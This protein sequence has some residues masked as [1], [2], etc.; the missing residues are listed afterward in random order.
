MLPS[1]EYATLLQYSPKGDSNLSQRSRDV[2]D[3]IKAGRMELMKGRMGE[4]IAE[5]R[6]QLG[7]FLNKDVTLVPIP[8]SS[9]IR[10]ASLWP[11]LEIANLLADLGLGTVATCL[12]RNTAVKKSSFYPKADDRPSIAEHY[13]SLAVEGLVPSQHITLVDDILTLGRTAV[14]AGSRLADR[15]PGATIRLFALMR[16]KGLDK[17]V[18]TIL[19]VRLDKITYNPENGKCRIKP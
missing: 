5:H 6:H 3:A 11:A 8:R 7:P 10:K 16:T 4:I 17:D 18:D 13:A 9:P 14:A 15:F 2:R 12:V 19:N 1:I